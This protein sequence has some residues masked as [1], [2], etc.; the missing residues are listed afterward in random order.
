MRSSRTRDTT[1]LAPSKPIPTEGMVTLRVRYNE[2]DP[3]NVAHHGTFVAWLEMGRTELLRTCG[4][5]YADMEHAGVFLVVTRLSIDYKAPARYD[6]VVVVV[7]RVTGGGRARINHEYELWHDAEDGRGKSTLL[8]T[9][10]STLACVG[11]DGKPRALPEW[12]T[13]GAHS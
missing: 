11:A 6:D 3:M 1:D 7:T 10:S 4:V 13:A 8:A 12:L 5:T 9:A 2:C